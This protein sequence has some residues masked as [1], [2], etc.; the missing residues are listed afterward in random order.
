[1]A[2][3]IAEDVERFNVHGTHQSITYKTNVMQSI[4]KQYLSL[5]SAA[6]AEIEQGR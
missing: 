6:I 3:D 5:F 1:M 2:N 4:Y